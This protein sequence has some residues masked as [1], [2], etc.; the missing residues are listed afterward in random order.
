[1]TTPFAIG[2][3]DNRLLN[4]GA[5]YIV[6]TDAATRLR[7]EQPQMLGLLTKYIERGIA[8]NAVS[9]DDLAL[10]TEEARARQEQITSLSDAMRTETDPVKRDDLYRQIGDLNRETLDAL[11]GYAVQVGRLEDPDDLNERYGHLGLKFDRPMTPEAVKIE[12]DAKREEQLREA[13]SQATP[14]TL[15]ATA[16]KLGASLYS[17]ATDPLEVASM[18]IPVAGPALRATAVARLGRVGG[19]AAIGSFEGAVGSALTEPIYYG[20]S[21]SLQLDYDMSDAVLNVG[22]GAILGGTL[23]AV[24]GGVSRA[25]DKPSIRIESPD[26]P[27]FD[28]Q[29]EREMQ[30]VALRQFVTGRSVDV[31]PLTADLR[32]S[33]AIAR[34]GG[35]EYQTFIPAI[36]EQRPSVFVARDGVPVIFATKAEAERVGEAIPAVDARRDAIRTEGP[37]QDIRESGY[38]AAIDTEGDIVRGATGRPVEFATRAPAE[39]LA[40]HVD[41]DVVRIA[42]DRFMVA[43]GMTQ[44]EL[45]AVES[46]NAIIPDGANVRQPSVN[47]GSGIITG[48]AARQFQA[49]QLARQAV[50]PLESPRAVSEAAGITSD[51]PK[52]LDIEMQDIRFSIEQID[53]PEAERASVERDIAAIREDVSARKRV[54]DAAIACMAR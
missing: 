54:L 20:L 25:L 19:I 36:P 15:G 22:A 16:A 47:G 14:R 5:D 52:D 3:Q 21:R 29:F 13:L 49:Q 39:A 46:G 35:V 24:V 7:R 9:L 41:G 53:M 28:P 44:D 11:K 30:E 50:D 33:T 43:K 6:P 32:S 37:V 38:R 40:S 1:M 51:A 31:A 42:P 26:A 2:V 10:Q 45:R 48:Q 8:D 27:R 17:V 12:V 34:A 18:F 4:V 23:G